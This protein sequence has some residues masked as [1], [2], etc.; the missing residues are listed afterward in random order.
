MCEVFVNDE[1]KGIR[2]ESVITSL[3]VL[4]RDTKENHRN[5]SSLCDD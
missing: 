3:K 4:S 2:E 1:L 5:L